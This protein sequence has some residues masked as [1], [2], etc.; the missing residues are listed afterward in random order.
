MGLLWSLIPSLSWFNWL[1]LCVAFG[2]WYYW[3]MTKEYGVWEK[4]GFFSVKPE[5]YFGNSRAGL[6]MTKSSTDIDIE[7]YQKFKKH[8]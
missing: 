6:L 7:L 3:W 5:F 1:C 8:K 2:L 4:K